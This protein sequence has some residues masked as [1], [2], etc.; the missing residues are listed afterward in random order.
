MHSKAMFGTKSAIS[1]N[2]RVTNARVPFC[3]GLGV[4]L[5]FGDE[6]IRQ[7]CSFVHN[8]NFPCLNR[9]GSPNPASHQ[10]SSFSF[11]RFFLSFFLSVELLEAAITSSAKDLS[12]GNRKVE[13]RRGTNT[14]ATTTSE[15]KVAQCKF[16]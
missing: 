14:E 12:N 7:A 4:G 11:L 15:G 2:G 8:S 9:L 13:G 1:D 10:L 6:A 5:R 3:G 16:C